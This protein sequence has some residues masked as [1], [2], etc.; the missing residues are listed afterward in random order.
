MPC[1]LRKLPPRELPATRTDVYWGRTG[2]RAPKPQRSC[3]RA[4]LF[5]TCCC[6]SG[7]I[8]SQGPATHQLE[9]HQS[10]GV[11]TRSLGQPQPERVRSSFAKSRRP[12]DDDGDRLAAVFR[13]HQRCGDPFSFLRYGQSLT[14]A[15]VQFSSKTRTTPRA[16]AR[17]IVGVVDY[18]INQGDNVTGHT[19]ALASIT[20]NRLHG[21]HDA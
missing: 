19:R 17:R 4:R 9:G 6:V 15:H 21:R 2:R 3:Q 5:H 7:H 8:T 16:V 12:I 11:S 1:S 18:A 20:R 10:T 13:T 14:T